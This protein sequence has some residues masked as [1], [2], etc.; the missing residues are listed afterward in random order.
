MYEI[1]RT[2]INWNEDKEKCRYNKLQYTDE[3]TGNIGIDKD[4]VGKAVA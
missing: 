3:L 4:G 2:E 1:C